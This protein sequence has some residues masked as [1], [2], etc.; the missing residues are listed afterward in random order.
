[1]S[2]CSIRVCL[3]NI[4]NETLPETRHWRRSAFRAG[5]SS[6]PAVDAG[7]DAVLRLQV[8]VFRY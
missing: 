5:D 8:P 1:M 4:S 2:A 3:Y 7:E 6:L